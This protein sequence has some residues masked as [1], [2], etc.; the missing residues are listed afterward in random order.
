M[1]PNLMSGLWANLLGLCKIS[2]KKAWFKINGGGFCLW[3]TQSI[4]QRTVGWAIYWDCDLSR[5]PEC[6]EELQK[7]YLHHPPLEWCQKPWGTT[8]NSQLAWTFISG[9]RSMK[10]LQKTH[11]IDENCQGKNVQKRCKFF[12]YA[13]HLCS[14]VKNHGEP[15][16]IRNCSGHLFL[17]LKTRKNS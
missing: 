6:P 2:Q 1:T 8:K 11:K 16:K 10:N 15:P 17:D 7:F 4:P 12:T 14:D 13:I 5:C 9:P 3:T